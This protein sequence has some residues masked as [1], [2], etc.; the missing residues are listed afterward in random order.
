MVLKIPPFSYSPCLGHRLTRRMQQFANQFVSRCSPFPSCE[1]DSLLASSL[2]GAF[3]TGKGKLF[4]CFPNHLFSLRLV[5]RLCSL[6]GR[7][8]RAQENLC[9][10]D[11]CPFRPRFLFCN[12]LFTSSLEKEKSKQRVPI[13]V[14]RF[15]TKLSLPVNQQIVV[16]VKNFL[17][18]GNPFFHFCLGRRRASGVIV[19][20]N[21]KIHGQLLRRF[22]R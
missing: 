21:P 4:R 9:A 20:K 14:R 16:A 17:R 7:C 11:T 1:S 13:L 15:W 6:T 5:L 3:F 10:V 19:H 12:S 2:V 8:K 22:P 18:M